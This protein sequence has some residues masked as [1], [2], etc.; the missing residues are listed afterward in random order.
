MWSTAL[1]S[2]TQ[3]RLPEESLEAGVR[4]QSLEARVNGDI[5]HPG[6]PFLVRA[7]L[8][9]QRAAGVLQRDMD[10]RNVIGGDMP[11]ARS[12]RQARER[13]ARFTRPPRS[14]RDFFGSPYEMPGIIQVSPRKR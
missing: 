1:G 6:R 7:F 14:S 12:P 9:V 5:T 2:G 11:A 4:A 10:R 13:R 8:P 3:S